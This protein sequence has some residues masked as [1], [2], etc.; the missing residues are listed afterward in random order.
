MILVLT[1]RPPGQLSRTSSTFLL[2]VTGIPAAKPT[3]CGLHLFSFSSSENT[4]YG[5]KLVSSSQAQPLFACCTAEESWGPGAF[6]DL[7]SLFP[8]CVMSGLWPCP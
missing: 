3:V 7:E 2:P 8:A 4:Q 1:D 5:S 6:F